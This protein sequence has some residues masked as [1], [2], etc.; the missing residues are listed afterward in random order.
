M[1][2]TVWI[3]LHCP[4]RTSQWR[5]TGVIR[6]RDLWTWWVVL[7]FG[8]RSLVSWICWS[9]WV[10]FIWLLRGG[11]SSLAV[12]I[13]FG[14]RCR[15]SCR[16]SKSIGRLLCCFERSIGC[17]VRICLK[18]QRKDGSKLAFLVWCGRFLC[19]EVVLWGRF[20][21]SLHIKRWF[22]CFRWCICCSTCSLG[23][24]LA[25][26]GLRLAV[27][28][29]VPLVLGLLSFHFLC[30]AV[31]LFPQLSLAILSYCIYYRFAMILL[32]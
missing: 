12:H 19:L 32:C 16:R 20:D 22:C 17:E 4:F 18:C 30:L 15:G 11:W 8:L 23:R 26:E 2:I 13:W 3:K 1:H 24:S 29:F 21:S 25:S 10:R 9:C 27:I 7:I 6:C 14:S 28:H 31:L 5:N